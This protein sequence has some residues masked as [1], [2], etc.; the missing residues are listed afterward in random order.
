MEVR[1]ECTKDFYIL[2]SSLISDRSV[3]FDVIPFD[4]LSNAI[5]GMVNFETESFNSMSSASFRS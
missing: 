5:F 2:S 1:T 4:R 3:L